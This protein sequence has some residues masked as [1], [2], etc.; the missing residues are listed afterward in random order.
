MS[1]PR[2]REIGRRLTSDE[3]RR[4]AG[5][6]AQDPPT[7]G[8]CGPGLGSYYCAGANYGSQTFCADTL[9]GAYRLVAADIAVNQCFNV[10]QVVC[11]EE[12]YA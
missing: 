2:T 5:A 4:V 9:S 12:L 10:E 11:V 8:N 6:V 3:Q 7:G 1:T